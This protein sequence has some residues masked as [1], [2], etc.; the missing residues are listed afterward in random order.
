MVILGIETTCDETGIAIVDIQGQR[1][2]NT[3][4]QILANE[5]ASQIK[6]HARF[7]GVYPML[8]KR[9]HEKNLPI[10]LKKARTAAQKIR[11]DLQIDAIAIVTG[12]GLAPCLWVG[13]NFA[14][15]LAKT[16]NLPLIPVNHLEG[17]LLTALLEQSSQISNFQLSII[18]RN[19]FPAIAL[20]VSGGHTQLV[21]IQKIGA[22]EV[23]GETRDD[24]AGEC[25]DKTARILGLPYP[26]GPAIAAAAA[27]I[28]NPKSKI[29][30]KLNIMLPRPMMHSKD[31]DFSF[32]GLKTAVLYDYQSRQANI[33]ASK[34]YR[35]AMAQEIQQAICDVLIFKTI[36]AAKRYQAKSV[37]LAGGVSANNELR[38]QLQTRAHAEKLNFFVSS[39][40]LSTDNGVMA[41]LAG[42][43]RW[44]RKEYL[45][46]TQLLLQW[47]AIG[48]DANLK[49]M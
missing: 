11:Q 21:H 39:P 43:V 27:K 14:K 31:F 8:A 37:I 38:E 45:T 49:L 1:K 28:Q 35:A 33:R 48:A 13:V 12:P 42:S 40:E 5:I 7:G 20:I 19:L 24:A 22:Y 34:K 30:K 10:V 29:Q 4:V 2:K 23:I 25:F 32:S 3:A 15:E 26:G 47:D 6:I 16:T 46:P 36:R 44:K 9:E 18:K 17:H 41:A